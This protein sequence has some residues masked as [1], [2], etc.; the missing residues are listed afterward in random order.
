MAAS[1]F[2]FLHGDWRVRHRKL[3]RR[4]AGCDDWTEFTGTVQA[5]P[6]L[7][8]RG[9][10]D[11]NVLDTPEGRVTALTV[12]VFDPAADT[13]TIHWLDSRRATFDPPLVGRF[14]QGVGTFFGDDA[15]EGRPVRVR[16]VWT[17]LTADSARWEQAFSAD[18]GATWETNW[19][20]EFTRA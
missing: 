4:L 9:N 10:V 8:G 18:D 5:R 11:D 7:D 16:F 15:H 6:A 3:K 17:P 12:R 13:W 20:M 2:D 1:D 14:A 19:I